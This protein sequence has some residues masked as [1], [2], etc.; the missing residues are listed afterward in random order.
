MPSRAEVLGDGTIRRQKAL[1][2]TG[3]FEPLHAPLAL[4]RG[5]MEVLTP[6]VEITALAMFHSRENLAFGGTVAFEPIR[7]DHAG[8][9]PQALEQLANWLR[10][11]GTT[12]LPDIDQDV[13]QQF[14]A[15][16]S[17]LQVFKTKPQPLA[18]VLPCK[19]PI[20]TGSQGVDSGIEEPFA[21]S[22]GALAV[23]GI[24][25]AVGDH[26][27][28]EHARAIVCGIKASV[29]IQIG[30]SKVQSDHLGHPLQSF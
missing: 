10:V 9:I 24:L 19:S 20:D 17:L 11:L 1:G 23:A 22:L 28:I 3:G 26:A 2:M 18:L 14:H 4:T 7:D 15:K 29:E 30:S 8:H 25:C 5:A 16:V 6:V 13:R 12:E 21:P 27:S